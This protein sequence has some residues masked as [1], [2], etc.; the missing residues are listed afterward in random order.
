MRDRRRRKKAANKAVQER[1][2]DPAAAASSLRNEKTWEWQVRHHR[3]QQE[4]LSKSSRPAKKRRKKKK[5]KK[6]GKKKKQPLPAATAQSFKEAKRAKELDP[7]PTARR[8]LEEPLFDIAKRD[9]ALLE[10]DKTLPYGNLV[11]DKDEVAKFVVA[12]PKVM[13]DFNAKRWFVTINHVVLTQHLARV[14]P[15]NV[16]KGERERVEEELR[17]T[18][19]TT[20]WD[21]FIEDLEELANVAW[22]IQPSTWPI[23]KPEFRD[24]LDVM[25]P[26]RSDSRI[27]PNKG[28]ELE[29]DVAK[30]LGS[31]EKLRTGANWRDKMH[32]TSF[33]TNGY[34]IHLLRKHR[35]DAVSQAQT[36]G[37][38]LKADPPG[39][40]HVVDNPNSTK[41]DRGAIRKQG[42]DEFYGYKGK[43]LVLDNYSGV[44]SID[45]GH[46][47]FLTVFE[48]AHAQVRDILDNNVPYSYVQTIMQ[49]LDKQSDD[50]AQREHCMFWDMSGQRVRQ[51]TRRMSQ[52]WANNPDLKAYMDGKPTLKTHQLGDVLRVTRYTSSNLHTVMHRVLCSYL[53]KLKFRKANRERS[54]WDS[55]IA[56]LMKPMGNSDKPVL[57]MIGD[58]GATNPGGCSMPV[59]HFIRR[60]VHAGAQRWK[61]AATTDAQSQLIARKGQGLV[62]R[63]QNCQLD[64]PSETDR[65]AHR[66]GISEYDSAQA[67][68]IVAC[69]GPC[70]VQ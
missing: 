56:R 46:N 61:P 51:M 34:E 23:L 5:G 2:D 31:G 11:L 37:G 22:R 49:T 48:A 63:D 62:G 44:R 20:T 30:E 43:D 14:Q 65:D 67:A 70:R 29:I 50:P 24:P 28:K 25:K 10:Q 16:A 68:R 66:Q 18:G 6:G 55:L 40:R 13:P 33:I 9:L 41:F 36:I 45:P 7:E 3:N 19:S 60:L 42:F 27:G 57:I 26:G 54:F 52:F 35:G 69:Q 47:N 12:T 17:A 59:K 58:S 15:N 4:K 21:E 64:P 32:N 38:E 1:P 39:T 8:G 53:A